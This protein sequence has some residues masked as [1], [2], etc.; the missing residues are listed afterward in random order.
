MGIALP[1]LA[2]EVD[3]HDSLIVKA[4]HFLNQ[5]EATSPPPPPSTAYSVLMD[6]AD[7]LLTMR[8]KGFTLEWLA[9]ALS[10]CGITVS[11]G[12]LE[13]VLRHALL[14]RMKSYEAKI[15]GYLRRSH[16]GSS[17]RAEFIEQGLRRAVKANEG[18]VLHYQPQVDMRTGA[19]VGAEALLR[20]RNGAELVSPTEFI[21]VAE[22]TGLIEE[23][24]TW[25][26]RQA[27]AEAKHWQR[28]GLGHEIG[29]KVSVNLSVKQ[30]S[31]GLVD[32]IHGVL[33][34]TGLAIELL[35]VEITESFLAEENSHSLLQTLHD[36]GLHLSI[37]D[38]GTG[39]SCLSSVSTLPLDTI[40][41]D[42]AF[43]TGIGRSPGADAVLQALITMADKLGMGTIAEG[44]ETRH[45]ADSLQKLGCHV[46]Q[47][48]LFSKPLPAPEFIQ[49]ASSRSLTTI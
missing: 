4:K 32:V 19:L 21:P 8:S 15:E 7:Q 16:V 22:E 29:I 37:D 6:L 44:V 39:Y 38:F 40:K 26:L 47:G 9:L 35:G 31:N 28:L 36:T 3:Q 20:W 27:C 43:V 24:G 18:L 42:R 48:F 30:F 49:F 14:T 33:C 2:Q 46:A 45:Q 13:S 41:I 17:E 25:V 10:E 23:I 34:D 12:E 1:F 5:I 11:T